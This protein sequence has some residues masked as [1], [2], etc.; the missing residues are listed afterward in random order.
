MSSNHYTICCL[1]A[2]SAPFMNG[3]E[4]NVALHMFCFQ[5]GETRQQ[6]PETG[7]SRAQTAGDR[8]ATL[9]LHREGHRG[10]AQRSAASPGRRLRGRGCPLAATGCPER[11]HRS[12]AR[13]AT[14]A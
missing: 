14:S 3:V 4:M 10:R 12:G 2:D 7:S 5:L 1:E 11:R 9:S 6:Q 8:A 13:G